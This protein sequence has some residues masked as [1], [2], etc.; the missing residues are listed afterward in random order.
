MRVTVTFPDAS[1]YDAVVHSAFGPHMLLLETFRLAPFTDKARAAARAQEARAAARAEA[2]VLP[3]LH[4]KR[5]R[6]EINGSV[7]LICVEGENLS[8]TVVFQEVA[9]PQAPIPRKKAFCSE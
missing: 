7:V 8:Q 3:T 6:E 4:K 2:E 9:S 1:E 5:T